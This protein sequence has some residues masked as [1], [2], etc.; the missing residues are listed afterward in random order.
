MTTSKGVATLQIWD[1]AGQEKYRALAPMYFRSAGVAIVCFD[2]TNIDSF[3]SL[4]IWLNELESKAPP[5]IPIIVAGNKIDL[6]DRRV[7]DPSNAEKYVKE[8]N[9]SE[10]IEVSAK[11][12]EGVDKLFEIIA[13]IFLKQPE[14]NKKDVAAPLPIER[15]EENKCC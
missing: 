13:D 4:D 15:K 9:V 11:T 6:E 8:R 7:I 2:V 10:Y 14:N 12:G 3:T 5:G 1:T